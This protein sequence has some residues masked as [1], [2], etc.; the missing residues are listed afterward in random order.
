MKKINTAFTLIEVIVSILIISIVI[1]TWFQLLSISSA[2]KIKLEE[3]TILEKNIFYFSE[4]L[5]S[6]IKKWWTLDYEEYFNRKIVWNKIKDWHYE[7][8]T[9]FWNFWYNWNIWLLWWNFWKNFYYC[10]SWNWIA[11]KLWSNWC[12]IWKNTDSFNIWWKSYNYNW[13]P[14]RYGQYSYQFIDYNSDADNDWWDENWDK[15]IIRD[16]D[17]THLWI[18]PEVFSSWSDVK[19]LYLISWDKKK[20]TYFRWN[21]KQDEFLENKP[22]PKCNTNLNNQN[23]KYCRGTVEFLE[24]EWRDFWLDHDLNINDIFQN[25]W[26]IDTWVISKNFTWKD[27]D[28]I[29][30]TS[31]DTWFWK[32]LFS[33]DINISDFK[34]FPYPN[35]DSSKAWWSWNS[36][37]FISPYVTVSVE[38][39]P[40]WKV[41]TKIK[42]DI[43]PVKFNTTINLTDIFSK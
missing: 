24:L 6:W 5:F 17:D 22:F 12:V 14:Q 42:W 2:T 11:N 20:R 13:Q 39:R 21:I 8:N 1:I 4:R 16:D 23:F 32:P 43:K 27:E 7:I 19:E 30:W 37:Y 9:W 38:I 28:I 25:D 40:S 31:E 41:K 34:V 10:L 35:I 29:A 18:W 36:S 15:K 33:D 26:V 3:Q